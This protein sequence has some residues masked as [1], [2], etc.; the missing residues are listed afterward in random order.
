M[1]DYGARGY[2]PSS[3]RF[4]TIDPLAE[5]YYSVS[6]YVYC[7]NNPVRFVDPDGRFPAFLIPAIPYIVD[8]AI[9]LG[10]AV[11]TYVAA[12]NI[13]K[14]WSK[15]NRK[16]SNSSYCYNATSTTQ[17]TRVNIP[18]AEVATQNT[19][20]QTHHREGRKEQERRERRSKREDTEIRKK[21]QNMVNNNV[22]I[23][24]PDGS[25]D[26]KKPLGDWSTI[27]IIVGGVG[28][29]AVLYDN[30]PKPETIEP[31]PTPDLPNPEPPKITPP[32]PNIPIPIP[33]TN[34]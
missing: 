21:H 5:K 13:S 16:S 2:Y 27:E 7:L 19:S 17:K 9:Y 24:T 32:S 33:K 15:R 29:A 18:T 4:T 22:G 10:M 11:T 14:E 34:H 30:I 28:T 3:M 12:R 25:P 26:P 20:K 23:P 6:P 1:F 31:I 8:G